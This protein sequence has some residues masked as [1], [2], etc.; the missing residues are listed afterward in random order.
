MRPTVRSTPIS[1]GQPIWRAASAFFG[2]NRCQLYARPPQMLDSSS[3]KFIEPLPAESMRERYPED[4]ERLSKEPGF[5]IFALRPPHAMTAT[6]YETLAPPHRS[7][8]TPESADERASPQTLLVAVDGAC[9]GYAEAAIN[10]GRTCG[11][12]S[13]NGIIRLWNLPQTIL[14]SGAGVASVAF[15]PDGRTLASGSLDGSIR[16]WDVTGP[17]HPRPLGQP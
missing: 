1:T 2:V 6:R 10:D 16:L 9:N 14:T 3:R 11:C 7:R 15:S 5:L 12:S 17:A 13:L 4:Y 8:P